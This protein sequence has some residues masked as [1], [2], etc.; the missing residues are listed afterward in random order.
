MRSLFGLEFK[1]FSVLTGLALIAITTLGF[2][3]YAL[4]EG[5][6]NQQLASRLAQ[7][8]T[9]SSSIFRRSEHY[10]E[11]APRSFSDYNRDLIVF[12]ADFNTDLS[13]MDEL[14]NIIGEDYYRRAPNQLVET[15]GIGFR[16]ETL[17]ASFY[18]MTSAWKTF[19]VELHD[20]LGDNPAEPRLEWGTEYIRENQQALQKIMNQSLE[21]LNE[22]IQLQTVHM[23][24]T[25]YFAMGL[26]ILMAILGLLWFYFGVTHRI[27]LAVAGCVRVSSGDFGYQMPVNSQDEIGTLSHAINNLSMRT[28]LVLS[29]VDN[30]RTAKDHDTALGAI[31]NESKTLFDLVWL[32]LYKLD[33]GFEH[34]ELLSAQP[35]SWAKILNKQDIRAQHTPMQIIQTQEPLVINDIDDFSNSRPTERLMRSLNLKIINSESCLLL[36]IVHNDKTWGMLIMISENRHAFSQE[37]MKLLNKLTP[38]LSDA[39]VSVEVIPEDTNEDELIS[40]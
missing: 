24:K 13:R 20:K 26:L 31:W 11:F 36:P 23:E 16:T 1:V 21:I 2:M 29:M 9:L 40:A 38:L 32:G 7:L 28:R 8:D 35:H 22:D 5:R 25:S 37:D 12:Y 3:I 10:L 15:L 33:D 39:F 17:D 18:K 30:I 34:M 6:T 19:Y 4:N 27:K 14:V